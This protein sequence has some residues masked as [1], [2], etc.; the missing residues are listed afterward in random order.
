MFHFP[1]CMTQHSIT[2]FTVPLPCAGPHPWVR[3]CH[4]SRAP[5]GWAQWAQH[6]RPH[7]PQASTDRSSWLA[8]RMETHWRH[9]PALIVAFLWHP[10]GQ[11]QL[12]RLEKERV[13]H[14]KQSWIQFVIIYFVWMPPS[15]ELFV[16]VVCHSFHKL[17]SYLRKLQAR[18]GD[19]QWRT[20]DGSWKMEHRLGSRAVGPP[21]LIITTLWTRS[22][23][24]WAR[25]VQNDTLVEIS[26]ES[27]MSTPTCWSRLD[28]VTH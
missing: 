4:T 17:R 6:D 3:T 14:W 21:P 26:E 2:A 24:S 18:Q 7:P 25:K 15:C 20:Q 8:G 23:Y 27:G 13:C 9:C 19:R 12:W 22:G 16:N 5:E 10:D 11:I 1:Y 28:I